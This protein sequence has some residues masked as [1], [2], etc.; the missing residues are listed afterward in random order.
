MPGGRRVEGNLRLRREMRRKGTKGN[1]VT[2][3]ELCC[4]ELQKMAK[5]PHATIRVDFASFRSCVPGTLAAMSTF[6]E[7]MP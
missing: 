3:G 1:L 4:T 6:S 7:S 5:M 2:Y